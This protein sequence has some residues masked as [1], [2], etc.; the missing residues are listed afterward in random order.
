MT[1]FTFH[2]IAAASLVSLAFALSAGSA[3]AQA[4]P[5]CLAAYNKTCAACHM[6]GGK[7]MAGLAPALAGTLTPLVGQEDGRK[8]IAGVLVHG[9][10]GKIVSQGVTF[11]GAMPPQSAV[12]DDEL[13]EIGNYLARDLNGAKDNVFTAKDIAQERTLK[14]SHKDL[15]DLRQR[16]IP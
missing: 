2:R 4:V 8:Y 5:N 3:S 6:P 12:S 7:G 1:A 14:T 13:A 10:S 9:L 16:L 11:M 15:R